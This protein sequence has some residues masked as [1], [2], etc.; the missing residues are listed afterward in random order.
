MSLG[1]SLILI[2]SILSVII[3]N[4]GKVLKNS[5]SE[6]LEI[7]EKNETVASLYELL[8]TDNRWALLYQSIYFARRLTL[9]LILVFLKEAPILQVFIM[10]GAT[11][12]FIGYIISVRPFEAKVL[13]WLEV[14]NEIIILG[15]LYH[16]IIF[17]DGLT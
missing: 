11:I 6:N 3:F 5:D 9:S 7:R 8:R 4:T 15:C 1:F 12:T 17:T 2:F 14:F 10:I 13:N 16:M